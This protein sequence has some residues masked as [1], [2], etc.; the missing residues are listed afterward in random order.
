MNEE[1]G[2]KA[3][4]FSVI[5][6]IPVLLVILILTNINNLS[7]SLPSFGS[8]K[9]M[10]GNELMSLFPNSKKGPE[11]DATIAAFDRDNGRVYCVPKMSG[12]ELDNFKARMPAMMIQGAFAEM[13]NPNID[14]AALEK[15]PL[16]SVL[17]ITFTKSYPC[18]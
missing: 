4:G 11:L 17:K 12:E 18:K 16:E 3:L 5:V 1:F 9:W 2:F 15:K 13:F 7:F 8:S 6:V 14:T 10:S